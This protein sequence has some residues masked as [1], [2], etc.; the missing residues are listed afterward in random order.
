M[1]IEKKENPKKAMN[2]LLYLIDEKALE[3][4]VHNRDC[5]DDILKSIGTFKFKHFGIDLYRNITTH[6]NISIDTLEEMSKSPLEFPRIAVAESYKTP[7][8]V[9]NSLSKDHISDV[10]KAVLFNDNID[11]EIIGRFKNDENKKI[12]EIALELN[13]DKSIN[14]EPNLDSNSDSKPKNKRKM[15]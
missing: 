6:E 3:N 4:V 5:S 7:S 15:R 12:K 2:D 14:D 11:D 13:S 9:L 8:Y 10:R 1:L